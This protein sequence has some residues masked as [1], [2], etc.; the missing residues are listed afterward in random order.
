MRYYTPAGRAIQVE[1]ITPDVSVDAAL[2]RNGDITV[3]REKD[4]ENHLGGEAAE[5][6]D[7]GGAPPDDQA[8]EAT[9]DEAIGID[10]THLG[11]ARTIPHN[12]LGGPD[13]A[14]S[15]AYEIILKR[16]AESR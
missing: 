16:L 2:S 13:Q 10:P 3:L 9:T 7:P 5:T 1:G 11:V 14:L 12:P 8:G 15:T 6:S 4:L